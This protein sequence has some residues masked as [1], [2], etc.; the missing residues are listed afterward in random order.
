MG[1]VRSRRGRFRSVRARTTLLATGLVT[2]ALAVAAIAMLLSVKYLLSQDVD[3]ATATRATQVATAL[4]N[5]PAG[6]LDRALLLSSP[7]V[8]VVQVID[9]DGRI[10]VTNEA[11]YSTPLTSPLPPGRSSVID[12]A[13]A[14]AGDDEYRVTAMG[15]R[16]P[17]G[18]LTVAA[19]AAEG[20]L[21][22]LIAIV[23]IAS[24]ILFP[25]IVI[26]MAILTYQLTGRALG[27]VRNIRAE[28]DEI[29]GGDLSRRVL[30]PDSADEIAELAIT[31]NRMLERLETARQRQL[32][33]VNDASHELNSP[34]TTLVGLLDLAHTTQTPIDAQTAGTVMLPDALRLQ[35]M[36]ADMLL[37]ARTDDG[38]LPLTRTEVDLDDIVAAEASRLRALT[39]LRITARIEPA[40]V[41]AD[42]DKIV[43]ALRNLADNAVRHARDTVS[44][45]MSVDPG[46]V[47]VLVGDDGEGIDDSDKDHVFDRFVR[48]DD[49]RSRS[50]GG[51]GLGLAIVAEIVLAHTGTVLITDGDDGGAV[52]GFTLPLA[53]QTRQPPSAASR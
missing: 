7:E 11:R 29:S 16:T 38:G 25:L 6:E 42:H 52:V 50:A 9:A 45:T 47:T 31:M 24:C 27:P 39:D 46:S 17:E 8:G 44:L 23:A 3:T 22:R 18:A 12:G 1:C 35:K 33:F 53:A 32:Q 51:S 4:E 19:G 36:V 15:V 37:L 21:N 2:L 48:L 40:R 43:R 14:D 26:G 30:V 10:V 41:D 20:P 13:H 49:A 5:T 28:V 34:L